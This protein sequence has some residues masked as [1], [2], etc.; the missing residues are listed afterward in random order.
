M[1]F[2]FVVFIDIFDNNCFGL[3]FFQSFICIRNSAGFEETL[4]L[5][6]IISVATHCTS[7]QFLKFIPIIN[8]FVAARP[9]FLEVVEDGLS[10]MEE[11]GGVAVLLIFVM[12][13]AAVTFATFLLSL[14]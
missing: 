1:R 13:E 11:A 5:F 3:L 8:N 4:S 6:F 10:W 9:A 12:L 14:H 2:T 7:W